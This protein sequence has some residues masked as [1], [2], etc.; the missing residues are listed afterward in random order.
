MASCST[1]SDIRKMKIKATLKTPSHSSQ[2]TYQEN[3][4]HILVRMGMRGDAMEKQ[5]ESP[6]KN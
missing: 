6:E 1:Y 5:Y 2:N 3:K 4:K